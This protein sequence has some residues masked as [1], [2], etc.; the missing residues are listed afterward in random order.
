IDDYDSNVEANRISVRGA[1]GWA[2][3]NKTTPFKLIVLRLINVTF[4]RFA[5]NL[6]RGLLQKLL[7]TGKQ[8]APFQFERSFERV[9][10]RW[11]VVDRIETSNWNDVES[12][13][14][15]PAQTSIYVAMSRTFQSGQL[16]AWLDLT[17]QIRMLKDGEPLVVERTL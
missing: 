13:G 10:N 11:K 14:I 2:K 16:Q 12:T 5:P 15:G 9:D 8:T 1:M 3:Q 17:P 7:I 4:G 6:V